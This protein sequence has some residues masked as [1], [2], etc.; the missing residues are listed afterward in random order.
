M[1][2]VK[3]CNNGVCQLAVVAWW[4]MC[5]TLDSFSTIDNRNNHEIT[6][7]YDACEELGKPNCGACSGHASAQDTLPGDPQVLT[8]GSPQ[9]AS[10]MS[11]FVGEISNL[12]CVPT[13]QVRDAC[14]S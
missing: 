4:P 1:P 8:A 11:L 5:K 14:P 7:F 10:F 9:R 12:L 6:S 13:G 2:P 3:S